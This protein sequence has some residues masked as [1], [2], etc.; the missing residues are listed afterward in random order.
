MRRAPCSV[1][2]WFPTE[3][4]RPPRKRTPSRVQRRTES[5]PVRIPFTI[6]ASHRRRI[7]VGPVFAELQL[8]CPASSASQEFAKETLCREPT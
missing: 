8:P 2:R 7:A 1:D 6:P 3:P 5:W 4:L